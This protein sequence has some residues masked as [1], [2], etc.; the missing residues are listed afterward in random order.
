MSPSLEHPFLLLTEMA[1]N[2]DQSE[3][4]AMVQRLFQVPEVQVGVYI[5][6]AA[7]LS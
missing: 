2:A 5:S 4:N 1:L 6:P 3:K 7:V